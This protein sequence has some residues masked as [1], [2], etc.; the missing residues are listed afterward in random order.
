MELMHHQCCCLLGK[1]IVFFPDASGCGR[2]RLCID[3][4]TEHNRFMFSAMLIFLAMSRRCLIITTAASES[5]QTHIKGP[6]VFYHVSVLP[7]LSW[8]PE[9]TLHQHQVIRTWTVLTFTLCLLISFRVSEAHIC[10]TTRDAHS[11][12]IRV[13]VVGTI[14]IY[15]HRLITKHMRLSVFV[16]RFF[17]KISSKWEWLEKSRGAESIVDQQSNGPDGAA[18]KQQRS[19]TRHSRLNWMNVMSVWRALTTVIDCWGRV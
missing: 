11:Q 17:I 9:L 3:A 1:V 18:L 15:D 12:D 14:W 4:E 5:G 6:V 19:K 10:Y 16:S 13:K 2:G 8:R 7:P